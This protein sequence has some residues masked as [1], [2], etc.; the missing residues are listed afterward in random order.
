MVNSSP[1]P[2][3]G[4]LKTHRGWQEIEDK[5]YLSIPYR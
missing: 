1:K 2:L 3:I 5:A 4:R